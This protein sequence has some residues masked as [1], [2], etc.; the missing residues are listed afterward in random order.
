M[1]GPRLSHLSFFPS[2][3]PFVWFP[4][5]HSCHM[6]FPCLLLKETIDAPADPRL[7]GRGGASQG[8]GCDGLAFL[9]MVDIF[10]LVSWLKGAQKKRKALPPE[11]PDVDRAFV[12]CQAQDQ[13]LCCAHCLVRWA[14]ISFALCHSWGVE[15]CQDALLAQCH[16]L[17]GSDSRCQK[18]AS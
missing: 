14:L 8:R 7:P 9:S 17:Q 6:A 18:P 10:A 1:D 5:G 11:V 16:I 4:A 12:R 15:F 3:C 13:E 2:S